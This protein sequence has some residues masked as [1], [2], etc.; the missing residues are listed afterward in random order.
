MVSPDRTEWLQTIY[1]PIED[2]STIPES[3]IYKTVTTVGAVRDIEKKIYERIDEAVLETIPSMYMARKYDISD[4]PVGT[5]VDYR[6]HEI[7]VMCPANAKYAKQ[8][9]GASGDS[10]MYYMTF[11]VYAPDDAV[12]FKEG[13]RGVVTDQMFTF[14]G[15]SS[16]IDK[17]GRKYSVC[18]LALAMYDAKT[19]SWTYF[20]ERSS[21]ERYIGWDYIVEWYDAN[22]IA[23]ASDC[24]RINLSN[25]SCHFS[26]EPYY[27]GY[28]KKEM[29]GSTF[30]GTELPEYGQANKI[31]VDKGKKV[32]S[33]WDEET[34][35]YVAIAGYTNEVT[36]EDIM[37]LFN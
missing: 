25:E 35:Q 16:G 22:G 5:L 18:W 36:D 13:D 20:G 28:L 3:E 8:S 37:N 9:V 24:V 17:L 21:T 32:I 12:S 4:T 2:V 14:N 10:N 31:Y 7:R 23:I 27:V 6:D 30:V 33:I 34:D 29:E 19:D 15:P 11:K 26:T 1:A